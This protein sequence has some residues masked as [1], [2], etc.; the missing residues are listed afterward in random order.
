[1]S[2]RP[3]DVNAH[4]VMRTRMLI[5]IRQTCVD[6]CYIINITVHNAQHTQRTHARQ[7]PSARA[8]NHAHEKHNA[9]TAIRTDNI[10]TIAIPQNAIVDGSRGAGLTQT[11]ASLSFVRPLLID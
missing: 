9:R 1:M 4:M 8:N 3:C 7:Q 5:R 10:A 2:A 6:A 11:P